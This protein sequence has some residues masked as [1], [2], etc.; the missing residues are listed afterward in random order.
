MY[1][2]KVL[3]DMG[4]FRNVDPKSQGKLYFYAV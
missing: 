4:N 2:P 3:G 1:I